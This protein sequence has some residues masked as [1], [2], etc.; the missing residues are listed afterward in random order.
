MNTRFSHQETQKRERNTKEE[1]RNCGVADLHDIVHGMGA[2]A[3]ERVG[4]SRSV[5]D[6]CMEHAKFDNSLVHLNSRLNSPVQRKTM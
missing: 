5:A 6:G 2:C 4:L 3:R 1:E